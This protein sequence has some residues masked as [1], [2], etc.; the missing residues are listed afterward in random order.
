MVGEDEA[1]YRKLQVE[2]EWAMKKLMEEGELLN[3]K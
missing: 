1:G 2:G 3:W